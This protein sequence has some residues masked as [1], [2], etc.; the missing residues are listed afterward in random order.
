MITEKK[1]QLVY[2]WI[3]I[4][5]WNECRNG[6]FK[7]WVEFN[8]GSVFLYLQIRDVRPWMP[9]GMVLVIHQ[10]NVKI[11]EVSKVATV[12][13][14][15]ITKTDI[16]SISKFDSFISKIPNVLSDMANQFCTAIFNILVEPIPVQ[17]QM[18]VQKK[19]LILS[20][21]ESKVSR[22]ITKYRSF[23]LQF[24][25]LLPFH[26][27]SNFHNNWPKLYL[28]SKP[29]LSISLLSGNCP[30]LHYKQMLQWCLFR[31]SR[32]WDISDT[33]PSYNLRGC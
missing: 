32:L 30:D 9:P 14:G 8:R 21:L 17:K 4:P 29:N 16:F 23:F 15:K 11:R 3:F 6:Y 19:A 24:W 12:L 26:R 1:F 31:P 25:S 13:Q 27:N 20:F 10:L 28:H 7:K 22:F 5:V 2:N 33:R 18:I